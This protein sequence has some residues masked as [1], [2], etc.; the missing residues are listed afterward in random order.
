MTDRKNANRGAFAA[1]VAAA[2]ILTAGF[3]V[4]PAQAQVL[5]GSIV[6]N[7]SDGTGAVIPGAQVTITHEET[8]AARSGESN[9]SGVYT[10]PT[11]ATGAYTVEVRAEGFR[12]HSETGVAVGANDVTRVDVDLQIGQVTEVVEISAEAVRLQTDRAEV[13][14]EVD[15]RDLQNVPV[16]LGRNYQMLLQ[17]IPGFSPPRNAHSVPANPTRAVR[18]S[19]NGTSEQS[20]NVRIDG[21]SSYN[22][23]LTHMQGI[24]PALESIEV[25]NVVTNS[26]DAEQGLAG[27]ASINLQ[28]KSGTNDLH[29]S[30]FWY[31]NNQRFQ[32]FPYF[33][34]TLTRKP[35]FIYNQAGATIGGPIKRNKAF[36]FFS[37]ERTAEHSNATKPVKVPTAAMRRGDFSASPQPIFDPMSA[38]VGDEGSRTAFDNNI[39]P[40][41]RLASASR[42]LAG[43]TDDWHLPNQPG[44]GPLGLNR[45]YL[46]GITYA[47]DRHQVDSKANF[48]LSD[49]W[50]AFARLSFFYYDQN[51]P[52]AFGNLSGDFVHPTNFRT[53]NGFGP[54]YSGTVSTTYVA[55]PNLIF[56]AYVGT[57]LLDSNAFAG[58]LDQRIGLDVLGI[59][60]TNGDGVPG[61]AGTF[62]GGMPRMRFDAGFGN[63]GYRATS[64]FIGH[65]FQYQIAV[66]GNWTKGNHEVRFGTDT[67]LIH[68]NQE[69]ANF[70]GGDAPAGGFRFR[71]S[72]TSRPGTGTTDYNSIASFM[73]GLSR[74][75][76]RNFLTGKNLQTRSR[77]Y[78]FYI[79]D[80]WQMRPDLTLS[81]G[82][83]WEYFPFPVRP[84]RGLERFDIDNNIMFVCGVGSVPRNCDLPQSKRLFAPR[85]GLAWRATD[86]FV[87]RAGYGLTYDPFNLGRDLRGNLPTQFSQR[88]PLPNSRSWSTTL[89]QGFPDIPP[90]PVEERIAMPLN[91]N[92]ATADGNY[93]RGYV[94]SWNFTLE[95]QVG[96]WIASAGYVATRS[97]RQ[98]SRLEANWSDLG[99]GN[100]GR[101][102]RQRYGRTANTLFWGTLG[103]P[104]YD[105]L[106]VKIVRRT[107][108][109][110]QF[111][112]AYTWSHGRGYA[113]ESSTAQ[114]RVRHP[115]YYGKNYGPLNQDIRHNLVISNA[116]E[117][118]FGK[119]KRFAQSGPAAAILGG[120]Q[121]NNLASLRTG[122]PVTATAPTSSLD[123]QGSSQFADCPAAPRKLGSPEGW[124]DI[125]TFADPDTVGN[126]PRFGACG[127][128]VLRGPGLI[129]VDMGIFRRFQ[130]NE[131]LSIQ[132][133][134]E[135]FNISNTPHFANPPANVGSPG[136]FG[137][138]G[139]MQ[140][141]GR[142]GLDQR[143]FRFGLRMGW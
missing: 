26:F 41:S 111:N 139:G 15:K 44:S 30:A 17:T 101:V 119:G 42:M 112:L 68:I 35:K 6:G 74:D 37:Y 64:P 92:V 23:N 59:P 38:A 24:N 69:V 99:T 123:S 79:R 56:D 3:N 67:F 94:Q 109:G 50:T 136:S 90:V 14:A 117:L 80:R 84:D 16:P 115:L 91:A 122:T 135:A 32:A 11:L 49:K 18:F 105:A 118:P 13:R 113:A 96:S 47:F 66:N 19:V 8:G 4:E 132:F 134:A 28:I 77:Q 95:K 25:V 127:V 33:K 133:R 45:N 108:S 86:T 58:N 100:R 54:T 12:T 60:G 129:N 39:I 75:S 21:A 130:V 124:W 140:N 83:R 9:A 70:P 116:W 128:G 43:M 48:N 36:Y 93:N 52:A 82:T 138:V 20:N 125:S 78:S 72:T 63:L 81:Y 103:T 141:T 97:V 22:P 46:A 5:Y 55:A 61:E 142:E 10:F 73:L 106:Q 104:K 53:D 114:P 7:V 76:A 2:L 1:I 107:N 137:V 40:E 85:V 143:V 65:D 62:Y 29:G 27:G 110:H 121:I 98:S 34:G 31:H 87:V 120:W 88:L 71:N 131:R 57:M 51:N 89:E 126:T 102:L